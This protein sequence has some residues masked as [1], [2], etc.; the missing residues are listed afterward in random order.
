M[1]L[2]ELDGSERGGTYFGFSLMSGSNDSTIKGL[3]VNSFDNSDALHIESEN[4][5]IQG[6]FIGTNISATSAK[7]NGVGL[8]GT[9]GSSFGENA[10]IGGLSPEDRNIISGNSVGTT[11]TGSYP[12]N[13]WIIQG[14]YIG[15]GANGVTQIGNSSPPPLGP[16]ALSIGRNSGVVVGGPQVGA[17]NV[18]SGNKSFGIFPDDTTGLVI[19]GN[20]IGSD[21][22]GDA[23]ANPQQVGGIGMPA[24]YG[25]FVDTLIGGMNSG[26]GNVIS[27]NNGT[28]IAVIAGSFNGNPFSPTENISILGN[29]IHSNLANNTGYVPFEPGLG[30][31]LL[32]AEFSDNSSSTTGP[33]PND[34]SD[35]DTGPNHFINFP[36]LNSV[37]QN[38]STASINFNLDAADGENDQYRVE[39]FSNDTPDPSGYGEGQTFLGATTVTNGNSQIANLTLPSGT[40]LADKSISATTT[41]IDSNATS[42]FGSTSE[43]SQ[44]V[45]ATQVLTPSP[46]PTIPTSTPTSSTSNPTPITNLASTGDN[47]KLL[48]LIA[49]LLLLGGLGMLA[50]KHLPRTKSYN[51]KIKNTKKK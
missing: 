27:H 19:Q 33:T 40:N 3:A 12:S 43:F 4:T 51:K 16:G 15:L 45:T 42:G 7:P 29:S 6:N 8:N 28:G 2:V 48:F 14:N 26:E 35:S 9:G 39:F 38:G 10:L 36:V 47:L 50:K 46:E 13:G 41:A 17:T 18:I 44:I 31:D 25:P 21:W 11:A 34:P 30:I 37:E 32:A 49:S 23:I 24:L 22:K 20:I 5:K 1:L